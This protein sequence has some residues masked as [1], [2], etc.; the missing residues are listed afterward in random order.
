MN[1][2]KPFI[3]RQFA[4]T[5][6]KTSGNGP[7]TFDSN[8]TLSKLVPR[9]AR[10]RDAFYK[11]L[12]TS[13]GGKHGEKLREEATRMRQPFA[14]ARQHLNQELARQRAVELQESLLALAFAEMGYPDASRE[15][16]AL[17]PAASVRMISE[18]RVRLTSGQMLA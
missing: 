16:A 2:S 13:V 1:Q 5:L 14:S 8:I 6:S 11:R 4:G 3:H 10:Y 17:I 18:I 9:I 7:D 12:I 15:R